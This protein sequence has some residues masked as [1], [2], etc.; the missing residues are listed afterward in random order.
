MSRH[1][2]RAICDLASESSIPSFS[3]GVLVVGKDGT[4]L[5]QEATL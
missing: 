1:P 5:R 4:L 2:K 3:S